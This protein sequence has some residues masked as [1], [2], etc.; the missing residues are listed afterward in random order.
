LRLRP[1][2]SAGPLT[3]PLDQVKRYYSPSGEAAPF[4]RQALIKLRRVAGDEALGRE[5]EVHRDQFV[6]SDQVWDLDTALDLRRRQVA[7]LVKPGT[8]NAKYSRGGVIDIEYAV[9]YLQIMHGKSH[10]ELRTSSTLEAIDG[11]L[12]VQL[13]SRQ[14]RD[15]LREAYLFLRAVIDGLRIVRGNA[16]DLVLPERGSDE[17]KFLARRLRYSEA[18]WNRAA[19]RL[20][21]A[22][23]RHMEVAQ[24]FFASRFEAG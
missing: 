12:R 22:I 9:Q 15:D 3:Y 2:G 4:E 23:S 8:V 18:N 24:R 10:A 7:E 5:L 11:L 1:H 14:E 13:V 20:E 16:R 19:T 6:Y 21:E 17:M